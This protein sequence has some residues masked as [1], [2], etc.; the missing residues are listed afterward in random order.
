VQDRLRKLSSRADFVIM[1][2]GEGRSYTLVEEEVG[3]L[4]WYTAETSRARQTEAHLF[5]VAIRSDL[6]LGNG[7]Y[8]SG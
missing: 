4:L 2:V 3:A 6:V 7:G 8:R 1:G 5:L